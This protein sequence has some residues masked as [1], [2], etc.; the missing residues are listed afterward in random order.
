M[1]FAVE[2]PP[3]KPPP[4]MPPVEPPLDGMDGTLRVVGRPSLEPLPPKKSRILEK[5][6]PVP[7]SVLV[8]PP[9][10]ILVKRDSPKPEEPPRSP[11][12]GK[13]EARESEPL[14]LRPERLNVDVRCWIG[15]AVA[16]AR[17]RAWRMI[18]GCMIALLL[19]DGWLRDRSS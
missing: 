9:E 1:S 12:R 13:P 5:S 14:L 3:R 19:R 16:T 8:P 2:L 15:A 17:R 7:D 6:R 10:K 18:C 11:E 4:M